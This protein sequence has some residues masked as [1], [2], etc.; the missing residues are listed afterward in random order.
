MQSAY[1]SLGDLK[2]N[3]NALAEPVASESAGGCS[4]SGGAGKSSCGSSGGPD[5]MPTD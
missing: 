2:A 1:I 3:R 5:D 4:S